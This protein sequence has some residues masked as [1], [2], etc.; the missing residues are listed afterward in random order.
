MQEEGPMT[1]RLRMAMAGGV[2]AASLLLTAPMAGAAPKKGL[3]FD[4]TCPGLGSFQIVTPPGNGAFTPA[5]GA[6]RVFIS[7]R[8]TGTVSVGGQV[9]D[10]FDD[11]KP[12]RVPS[13]AIACAFTTTFEDQGS[14]VTIAGTALVVP[15][16]N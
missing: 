14:T 3:T 1:K 15:R 11:I 7:Y 8:V 6:D 10:Q 16:P 12:A 4:V 9:V 2:A 13:S 5:F